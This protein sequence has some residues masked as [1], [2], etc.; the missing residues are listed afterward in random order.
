MTSP[1]LRVLLGVVRMEVPVPL[2]FTKAGEVPV[3]AVKLRRPWRVP[4]C[5]GAKVRSAVQ[6]LLPGSRAGQSVVSVKSPVTARLRAKGW[7]PVLP[8]VTV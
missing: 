3:P 4:G 7:A 8:M 1:K 6:V 5:D 2:R